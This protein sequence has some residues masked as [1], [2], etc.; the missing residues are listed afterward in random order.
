[1][2][3][4]PEII[5]KEAIVKEAPL[6]Y[7][8]MLQAFEAYDTKLEVPSSA[9]G[10]TVENV[11]EIMKQGGALLAYEDTK[12]VGCARY[13]LKSDHLYV[14]RVSVLPTYRK[15]GI[16]LAL[17]R[18]FEQIAF[19]NG[20]R[21]IRLGVRQSLPENQQFYLKRGYEV[22]LIEPHPRGN[23]TII[24]MTFIMPKQPIIC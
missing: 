22:T 18:Y 6:V 2:N 9:T 4:A 3:T 13:I 20:L 19:R 7:S 15:R 11:V 12:A 8:I 16:G 10:E 24:W 21:E 14:G 23:D 17:M 5:I 1:M